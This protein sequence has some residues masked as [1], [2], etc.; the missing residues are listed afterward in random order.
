[1]KGMTRKQAEAM[2]LGEFYPKQRRRS[3]QKG[4]PNRTEL[5]YRDD[6]ITPR[7]LAGEI[8]RAEFEP[9]VLRLGPDCTYTPDW[10]LTFPDGTHEYHEIKGGHT[11]EDGLIKLKWAASKWPDVTFY[12]CRWKYKRWTIRRIEGSG[13]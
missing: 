3:H 7:I 10:K 6:H 13:P 12:L 1:M 4:I 8:V 9:D 11:F 2:G 5:R